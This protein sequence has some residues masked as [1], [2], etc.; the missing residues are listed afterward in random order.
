LAHFDSFAA[1]DENGDHSSSRLGRLAI[2]KAGTIA[3][4]LTAAALLG[5]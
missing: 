5:K 4:H 2:Q 1:A 3:W